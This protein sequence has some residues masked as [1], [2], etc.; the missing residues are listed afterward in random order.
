MTD[1]TDEERSETPE[2]P[3]QSDPVDMHFDTSH[4]EPGPPR[5]NEENRSVEFDALKSENQNLKKRVL[6]LEKEKEAIIF[7][8][9]KKYIKL[10]EKHQ[11]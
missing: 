1:E 5:E 7:E 9:Q 3:D 6:Q 2:L 4:T 10:L 8:F 11:K